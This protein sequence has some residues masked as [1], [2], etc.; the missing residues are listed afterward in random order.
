MCSFHLTKTA[1][2]QHS[3]V[4]ELHPSSIQSRRKKNT[5]YQKP[6][7]IFSFYPWKG[8]RV[9]G[10][11]AEGEWYEMKFY[12]ITVMGFCMEMEMRLD[13]NVL[14]SND[15]PWFQKKTQPHR[16]GISKSSH[17]ENIV[18]VEMWALWNHYHI[19]NS[20]VTFHGF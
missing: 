17:N 5:L 9:E 6:Y 12:K 13:W 1:N 10:P 3:F 2:T 4:P 11:C 18:L 15:I 7:K 19:R 8:S 16:P 14:V 20:Y